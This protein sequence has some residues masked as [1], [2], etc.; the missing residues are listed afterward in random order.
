MQRVYD[1]D[2]VP[3][4][5]GTGSLKYDSNAEHN[6]PEDMLSLWV[7]DMDFPGPDEVIEAVKKTAERGV[8]GYSQAT[9]EY[10]E[11]VSA[12][13][14]TYFGWDVK[15]EWMV[16]TPGVV[17]SIA[18]AIRAFTEK[19][20]GVL[21]QQAVYYPF[22]QVIR[23][24]ERR[25][26][27]NP[28]LERN[29]HYEMDYADLEEKIKEEKIKLMILCSPHNPSGRVWTREELAR[30]G[31]ICHRYGVIVVSDEIHSDFVYP[32]HTHT[33]FSLA[34]PEMADQCVI[35][36]AP[37]KTFNMAGLQGS[38]IFISNASLRE[39]FQKEI[40][41]TG[42]GSLNQLSYAATQAAYRYGRNWFEQVWA[43][44]RKNLEFA[45]AYLGTHLPQCPIIEPEGTYLLWVDMRSLGLSKEE[46]DEVIV[47][48]ARLWLDEGSLFG[49]EGCGFE[50]FN[51]A[52]P[53]SVLEEALIRLAQA[54]L[55]YE[56]ER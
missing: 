15:R 36:T 2:H 50:R 4:R 27:D 19:G 55:S 26:V 1:F 3:D 38:N 43:Y 40:A 23:D 11:A 12:W 56:A 16:Q 22:A 21:I 54:V 25:L 34:A 6:M 30:L 39:K 41:A 24:N 9:P 53:R 44:I 7:A 51:L 52:C 49:P 46:R 37:S 29:G 20:D 31:E 42:Y 8:Y 13:Y 5:R 45:R 48:R 33:I 17:F 35:C 28:L 47:N 10:Y 18:M 32:G 14:R